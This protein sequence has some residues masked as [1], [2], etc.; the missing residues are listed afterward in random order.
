MKKNLLKQI[1]IATT[2]VSNFA[3]EVIM[4][5][6]LG[7]TLLTS[8]ASKKSKLNLKSEGAK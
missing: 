1:L 6:V 4:E 5:S 7:A 8:W 3:D 2:H